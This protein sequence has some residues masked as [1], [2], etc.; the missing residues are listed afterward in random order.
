MKLII[1]FVALSMIASLGLASDPSPLQDFCVA[2][3]YSKVFVNGKV[4]KDPMLATAN[5]FFYDGL[6]KPDN[7]STPLGSVVTSVN[8]M[9][10][11]RLNTLGIDF[12]PGGKNPP[13]THPLGAEILTV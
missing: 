4:C 11:P 12:V 7:T 8:V 3:D 2:D 1:V 9:Q 10:M 13:H 5:D 6:D